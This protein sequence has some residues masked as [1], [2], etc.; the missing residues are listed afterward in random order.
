MSSCGCLCWTLT[1]CEGKGGR[2][3][4]LESVHVLAGRVP[5]VS[6]CPAPPCDRAQ[7][8]S[9]FKYAFPSRTI[10]CILH[11]VSEYKPPVQ[12]HNG[13]HEIVVSCIGG[14][15]R[16]RPGL[17]V[18]TLDS[19]VWGRTSAITRSEQGKEK[20]DKYLHSHYG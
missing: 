1:D 11:N 4:G 20:E 12:V 13:L 16:Q 14:Y 8:H 3:A 19:S 15:C 2:L 6:S 9:G 7:T 18:R 10:W 5:F 17:R